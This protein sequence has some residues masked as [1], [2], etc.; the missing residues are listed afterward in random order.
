MERRSS[1]HSSHRLGALHRHPQRG[2][3][4]RRPRT[5]LDHRLPASLRPQ[6]EHGRDHA[7]QHTKWHC[8][9]CHQ[10]SAPPVPALGY[11]QQG[12]LEASAG[13]Q[14]RHQTQ[15]AHQ[16]TL[17]QERVP[18]RLTPG[19]VFIQPEPLVRRQMS[20]PLH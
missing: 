6:H 5:Q 19:G 15:S 10:A 17:F 2:M 7:D 16:L 9:P 3:R 8:R 14:V 1:R 13:P 12:R 11:C 4:Y 18:T 20:Q